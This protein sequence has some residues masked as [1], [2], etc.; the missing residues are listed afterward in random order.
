MHTEGSI[1]YMQ[2]V[3]HMHAEGLSYDAD[4]LSQ[5]SLLSPFSE[6]E[7]SNGGVSPHTHGRLHY[8]VGREEQEGA[9]ADGSRLCVFCLFRK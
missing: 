9:E 4:I 2:G 6:V 3:Y 5:A 8:E 7:D 1:I